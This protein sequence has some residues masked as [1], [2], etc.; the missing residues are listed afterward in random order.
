LL[1]YLLG[2]A[3]GPVIPLGAAAEHVALTLPPAK[4]PRELVSGG[5]EVGVATKCANSPPNPVLKL[6]WPNSAVAR[7]LV[8]PY[9]RSLSPFRN[10]SP[11]QLE[12]VVEN[13]V[14]AAVKQ[15]PCVA[16]L[17]RKGS[18]KNVTFHCPTT[19]LV[20]TCGVTD[21]ARP[22]AGASPAHKERAKKILVLRIVIPPMIKFIACGGTAQNLPSHRYCK[23]FFCLVCDA[24]HTQF[25]VLLPRRRPVR[26]MPVRISSVDACAGLDGRVTSTEHGRTAQ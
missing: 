16:P 22:T 3:P 17:V 4:F 9:Q 23:S 10:Q 13:Q 15:I 11:C 26:T 2:S 24:R 14:P 20:L 8:R 6:N 5:I 1:V 12:N 21:W 19:L 25:W 7:P 18:V